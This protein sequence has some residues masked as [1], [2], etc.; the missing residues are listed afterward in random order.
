MID[1]YMAGQAICDN[2]LDDELRY[3]CDS[4]VLGCLMTSSRKL[5]IWPKPAAPFVGKRLKD[6]VKEIRNIRIL[7]VCN[8]TSSRRWNSH[9]PS[10]NAHGLEDFIE[11]SMSSIEAGLDGL[12]LAD[13]PKP[14]SVPTLLD[15]M[16]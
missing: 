5:G 13:Y 3:A 1:R 16:A 6:L 2:A 7:D 8:K 10:P 15:F 11:A 9:G 12:K 4:M 14:R